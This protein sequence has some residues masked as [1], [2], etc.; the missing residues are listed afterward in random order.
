MS[1]FNTSLSALVG[2][3]L[4]VLLGNGKKIKGILASVQNDYIVMESDKNIVYHSI[5]NIKGF[6]RNTKKRNRKSMLM[7]S[8][9]QPT[10][11]DVLKTLQQRWVS[12]NSE[13]GDEF[14]G[15]LGAVEE[16]HII[17]VGK[18][19]QIYLNTSH[20]KNIVSKNESSMSNENSN[21]EGN[22]KNNSGNQSGM[23]SIFGGRS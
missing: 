8:Y 13:N 9:K 22:S 16:D 1:Q 7:N 17:L 4:Q 2:D 11:M 3:E 15:I 12:I 6:L 14:S 5:N 19:E 18:E 21:N 10:L 23:T 20:I